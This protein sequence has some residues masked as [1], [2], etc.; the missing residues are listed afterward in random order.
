MYRSIVIQVFWQQVMSRLHNMMINSFANEF[1]AIRRSDTLFRTVSFHDDSNQFLP[2]ATY[3]HMAQLMK[4]GML[5]GDLPAYKQCTVGEPMFKRQL[6][7][8]FAYWDSTNAV[9]DPNR[10]GVFILAP[11][12]VE[13][14]AVGVVIYEKWT[15][16]MCP[17][18]NIDKYPNYRPQPY[19]R[20]SREVMSYGL[21]L[22]SGAVLWT[23]PDQFDKLFQS[24]KFN[25]VPYEESF[26]AERFERMHIVLEP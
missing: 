1:G 14:Q 12:K 15:P 11:I 7:E 22:S 9:E 26:R 19:L 18:E 5:S 10:P 13:E 24:P 8:S 21:R 25:R 16:T 17:E 23:N 3:R 20:Y 4:N 6:E 2:Q